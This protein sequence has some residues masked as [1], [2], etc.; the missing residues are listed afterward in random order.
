MALG[1]GH[2]AG[3]SKGSC[4]GALG[5]GGRLCGFKFCPRCLLCA[6]VSSFIPQESGN[7]LPS[8][9][10]KWD[11]VG[12]ILQWCPVQSKDSGYDGR[13]V[14]IP[15]ITVHH[16]NKTISFFFNEKKFFLV[17]LHSMWDVSSLTRDQTHYP[18]HWK[19][20]LSTREAPIK[21]QLIK[22]LFLRGCLG[23]SPLIWLLDLSGADVTQK[24]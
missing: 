4:A 8:P 23:I 12:N 6:S 22:Q 21:K 15:I 1:P 17:G 2:S 7:L 9:E 20:G 5:S 24:H 3:A 11:N 18:L 19:R 14:T 10:F 16:Y 13:V